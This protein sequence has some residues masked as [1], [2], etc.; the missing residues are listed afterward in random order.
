M[1]DRQAAIAAARKVLDEAPT[2]EG[3]DRPIFSFGELVDAI[4]AAANPDALVIPAYDV[5]G[6]PTAEY[7]LLYVGVDDTDLSGGS[8]VRV[9]ALDKAVAYGDV[10][11]VGMV[12]L[13]LRLTDGTDVDAMLRAEGAYHFGLAVMSAAVE[14][15]RIREVKG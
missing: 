9:H 8:V 5:V 2:I 10:V 6:A 14:A 7:P 1:L 3:S 11:E 13:D 15:H 4:L 12:K